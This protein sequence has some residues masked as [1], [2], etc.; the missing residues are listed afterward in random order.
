MDSI[1]P[2]FFGADGTEDPSVAFAAADADSDGIL[3]ESELGTYV[4]T[5]SYDVFYAVM[6]ANGDTPIGV[7]NGFGIL[8][9]AVQGDFALTGYRI[10]DAAGLNL[11][12]SGSGPVDQSSVCTPPNCGPQ[13][14]G[15]ALPD[16]TAASVYQSTIVVDQALRQANQMLVGA[17]EQE[18]DVNFSETAGPSIS[19]S[20]LSVSTSGESTRYRWA[21]RAEGSFDRNADLGQT[22]NGSFVVAYG[23]K[24]DLDIGVYGNRRG[25]DLAFGGFSFDGNMTSVGVYLRK[26]PDDGIGMQWK[27]AIGGATGNADLNGRVAALEIGYGKKLGEAM[28]TSYGRLT[29][30]RMGRDGYTET[31]TVTAP[32]T[33]D[34][35]SQTLTT[36]TLGVN[37]DRRLGSSVRMVGGLY[38]VRDLSRSAD[39]VSGSAALADLAE[40]NITAP[41]VV[42]PTRIGADVTMFFEVGHDSRIYTRAGAQRAANTDKPTYSL[43]L[44]FE[45]RF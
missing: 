10:A 31:D 32:V 12:G 26:R 42:N 21:A 30:S 25:L 19:S 28:L 44:G 5:E 43:A 37:A 20:G 40:F 11:H 27:L 22:R 6:A 3:T 33:Y 29:Y 39:V 14:D 23:L 17:A 41:G 8:F 38:A 9:T 15:P 24:D 18:V 16:E 36:L 13:S 34:A 35:Y 45:T 1:A 2:F 4:W 7:M